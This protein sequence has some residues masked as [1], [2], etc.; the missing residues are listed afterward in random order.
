[1]LAF[2]KIKVQRHDFHASLSSLTR[3]SLLPRRFI[4]A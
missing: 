4:F 1:V 2:I 3:C